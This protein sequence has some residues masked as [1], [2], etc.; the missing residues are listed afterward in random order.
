MAYSKK[1]IGPGK[2]NNNRTSY[3]YPEYLA[4]IGYLGTTPPAIGS[5]NPQNQHLL[6]GFVPIPSGIGNA[7][8]RV[9]KLRGIRKSKT[10]T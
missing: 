3:G 4:E 9:S 8:R 5:E 7:I 6:L 2:G 1:T 10:R